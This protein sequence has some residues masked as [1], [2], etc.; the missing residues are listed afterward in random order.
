MDN[1]GPAELLEDALGGLTP[2]DRTIL[3]RALSLLGITVTRGNKVADCELSVSFHSKGQA[4]RSISEATFDVRT[5]RWRF[6][7]PYMGTVEPTRQ[8][9][10]DSHLSTKHTSANGQQQQT[11]QGLS[12]LVAHP[13]WTDLLPH[14]RHAQFVRDTDWKSTSLGP[15]LGWPTSLRLMTLKIFADPRSACLY[16]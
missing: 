7:N 11:E 15:M 14:T 13:D 9:V 16:W 6:V 2:D 12:A 5:R 8:N 4:V 10:E 3:D 1:V